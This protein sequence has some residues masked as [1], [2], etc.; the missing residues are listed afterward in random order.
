MNKKKLG[1]TLGFVS[2]LA[3]GAVGVNNDE[4]MNLVKESSKSYVENISTNNEDKIKD[5]Y[6]KEEIKEIANNSNKKTKDTDDKAASSLES[7]KFSFND[8]S[9]Q[10]KENAKSDAI[11]DTNTYVANNEYVNVSEELQ[12]NNVQ[13]SE[14]V[15]E[16]KPTVS[17]E[18]TENSNGVSELSGNVQEQTKNNDAEEIK[19]VTQ[20]N[21]NIETENELQDEDVKE[22]DIPKIETNEAKVVELP[23]EGWVSNNLN[24]RSN[25]SNQD[26]NI[27]GVLEV[28]TKISGMEADGWIKIDY[29]GQTGYI[30]R[31]YIS[32][33]EIKP[34]VK[35][36]PI[37]ENN[38][39]GWVK[40]NLNLREK[41]SNDSNILTVVPKGTQ[42]SGIESNGWVKVSYN[43][44]NGYI[45]N[46]YI[47]STEIKPDVTE[48]KPE[49]KPEEPI[50]EDNPNQGIGS[51]AVDNIVNGALGFV[52]YPY[53]FGASSPSTGFDCSG[54]VYYL[55][56]THAG[57]TLNRIAADQA[58]NGY[59]VSWSNLAPGDLLFFATAGGNGI[60]HVG[61][62]IGGGQMVHAST[63]ETGVITS[64]INIDYYINTFVTARRII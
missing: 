38:V 11:N 19:E 54:L 49:V 2:L 12:T 24:V 48:N 46:D 47:S 44:L 7:I 14:T 59:E 58:L 4:L 9:Y 60:S 27:I 29:S 61:I 5:N 57:I 43:N 33:T 26:D 17:T 55:Y 20:E 13:N 35:E 8:V 45:S 63:P 16:E 1:V 28:G 15:V 32:S 25:K 52:G 3:L 30:S 53:V 6:K 41:A 40:V 50:I 51:S 42:I 36:E 34:V 64:D 56:Q 31:D 23:I 62:Y 37:V 18:T 10:I 22:S 39:S 21:E